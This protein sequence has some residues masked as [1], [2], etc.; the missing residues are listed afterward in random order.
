[1]QA[2]RGPCTV[3]AGALQPRVCGAPRTCPQTAPA[4]STSLNPVRHV[5]LIL[6]T[7]SPLPSLERTF[8]L[9]PHSLRARPSLLACTRVYKNVEESEH[10]RSFSLSLKHTHKR[11]ITQHARDLPEAQRQLTTSPLPVRRPYPPPDP[12]TPQPLSPTPFCHAQKTGKD[13]RIESP[14]PANGSP[15]IE[16]GHTQGGVKET[17]PS[18][19]RTPRSPPP[20]YTHTPFPRDLL[21][22]SR[23]RAFI[24]A[25]DFSWLRRMVRPLHACCSLSPV[26]L[27]WTPSPVCGGQLLL[28]HAHPIQRLPRSLQNQHLRACVRVCVCMP[29]PRVRMG[30]RVG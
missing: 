27:A 6:A 18:L 22:L 16:Q 11:T 20:K 28:Q 13:I 10:S 17:G 1:M 25:V 24:A 15:H 12:A 19:P 3:T 21:P 7:L 8:C 23:A 5:S 30:Q 9:L 29:T 2:R 26:T 14:R 4:C